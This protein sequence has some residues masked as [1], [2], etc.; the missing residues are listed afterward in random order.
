M[1]FSGET[2]LEY[3]L[4][5]KSLGQREMFPIGYANGMSGYIPADQQIAGGGYEGGGAHKLFL[6]PAPFRTGIETQIK[7]TWKRWFK[8][9]FVDRP[10]QSSHRISVRTDSVHLRS[11]GHRYRSPDKK[12]LKP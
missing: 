3:G 10:H 12:L 8:I 2:V 6:L 9:G 1:G 5:V 7:N 4:H 11:T